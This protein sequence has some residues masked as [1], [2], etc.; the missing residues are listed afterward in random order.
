MPRADGPAPAPGPG[1]GAGGGGGADVTLQ[2]RVKHLVRKN[3]LLKVR[4]WTALSCKCI[5]T[6]FLFEFCLPFL[7]ALLWGS[8]SHLAKIQVVYT[9]WSSDAFE[10]PDFG[11]SLDCPNGSP[12]CKPYTG[13]VASPAPFLDT[14]IK[15]HWTQNMSVP[16]KIGLAVDDPA[17]LPALEQVRAASLLCAPRPAA[18]SRP[19][20]SSA[21]T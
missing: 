19:A 8:L 2:T 6:G 10:V 7:I 4:H 21:R 16:V 3:Y 14:L 1:A 12:D 11:A 13:D 9:G 17:D 20:F 18:D 15:L 5:P